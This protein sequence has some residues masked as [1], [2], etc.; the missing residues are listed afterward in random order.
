[1]KTKQS[2]VTRRVAEMSHTKEAVMNAIGA[3][4]IEFNT[5]LYDLGVAKAEQSMKHQELVR[6]PEYW[7]WFRNEYFMFEKD[8][9]EDMTYIRED[10]FS[11]NPN[12]VANN[13]YIYKR[14]MCLLLTIENVDASFYSF[15]KE[16]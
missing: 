5:F 9:L 11:G 7:K 14:E 10:F 3:S 6:M 13:N 16:F 4:L 1:M 8:L 2:Q 12:H 15:I